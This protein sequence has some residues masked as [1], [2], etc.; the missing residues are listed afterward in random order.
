MGTSGSGGGD[1][2]F[3]IE[4]FGRLGTS[5]NGGSSVGMA[6]I[7]GG[8]SESGVSNKRR[9]AWHLVLLLSESSAKR[10]PTDNEQVL[11]VM[12]MVATDHKALES[13]KG[14]RYVGRDGDQT[15]SIYS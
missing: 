3:G 4:G 14:I 15:F 2:S 8:C 13:D 6:G 12:V 11:E 5:G 7:E 10:M 9:A 1:V